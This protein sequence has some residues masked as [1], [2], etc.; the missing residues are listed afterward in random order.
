MGLSCSFW[1]TRLCAQVIVERSTRACA[2]GNTCN[3]MPMDRTRGSEE[4]EGGDLMQQYVLRVHDPP[5]YSPINERHIGA[6]RQ[7]AAS[8]T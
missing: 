2:G 1:T 5:L 8:L 4:H 3:G 6:P 7:N